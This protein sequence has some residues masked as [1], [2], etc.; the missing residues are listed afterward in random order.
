MAEEDLR[1]TVIRAPYDGMVQEKLADIGQFVNTGA[2]LAR[3][4]AVDRVE[5]RLPLSQ[6][7]LK[8]LDLRGLSAGRQLPVRLAAVI[9]GVPYVWD[10]SIVRSE[11]VFDAASRV[12]YVVAQIEDPYD[13]SGR[14]REPLR[15]GTFVSAEIEGEA[16]G[17]LFAIPR[18]A[19]TRG[20]TV[21]VIEQDSRIQPRVLEIVRSDEDFAYVSGGIEEGERYTTTPIEQPLPGMKVRVEG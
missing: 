11:G 21:W 9:G 20:Q 4:F 16:G 19:L 8:F 18:H 13:L 14:S 1:R 3:T 7:D 17:D 12:L 2:Q 6:Q 5:V 15:I 10:A